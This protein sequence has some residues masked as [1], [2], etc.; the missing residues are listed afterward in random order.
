[1]APPVWVAEQP[2]VT[3][4][5]GEEHSFCAGLRGH[6]QQVSMAAHDV[7]HR[8]SELDPEP[9]HQTVRTTMSM[10][11][12]ARTALLAPSA[13][14]TCPAASVRA[15]PAAS[16]S[17]T[18][19]PVDRRGDVDDGDAALD[20]RRCVRRE[21]LEQHLLEV[22]LS[23]AHRRRSGSVPRSA[24]RSAGPRRSASPRRPARQWA[25]PTSSSRRRPHP[26]GCAP[27]VPR[28]LRISIDRTLSTVALGRDGPHG[29]LSTTRTSAPARAREIAAVSPAA[30][31]PTTTTSCR[32]MPLPFHG[33]HFHQTS[34]F[35]LDTMSFK[36]RSVN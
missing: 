25:S 33:L 9:L 4:P 17:M 6:V 7:P 10:P 20:P 1:M 29:L 11:S 23:D 8:R 21:M 5:S 15:R 36:R 28:S 14:T 31:A 35:S 30:P 32:S 27:R 2:P 12:A 16:R 22:V 26:R 34:C 3:L 19:A 13:P 24:P 18:V